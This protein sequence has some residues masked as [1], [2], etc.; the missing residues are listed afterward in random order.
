MGSATVP[1]A[2]LYSMVDKSEEQEFAISPPKGHEGEAAG[3]LTIR[4]RPPTLGDTEDYKAAKWRIRKP[5]EEPPSSQNAPVDMSGMF[6]IDDKILLIEIL[7]GRDLIVA[8]KTG[9]SDPYVK[10]DMGKE[11]LHKTA[12]IKKTLNPV[13]TEED[14][15]SYVLDCTAMDLF[16]K[17]GLVFK[18]KDW[19]RGIGGNDEMGSVKIPAETLYN[20]GPEPR[21]YPI[22]PPPGK[23]DAAG[24][25][26]LSC[27]QIS[28][29]QRDERKKGGFLKR[30]RGV[31]GMYYRRT[32][33]IRHIDHKRVANYKT[34][35]ASILSRNKI[36]WRGEYH[37][38]LPSPPV[39]GPSI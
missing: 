31:P 12:V 8:D 4:C 23:S 11:Q 15:N 1:A 19:D 10:I 7:S 33:R 39:H 9:T 29:A 38:V 5:K 32:L 36:S 22:D 34:L 13:F 17:G 20:F 2:T 24:F 25:L 28:A 37:V 35:F 21:E 30:L 3:F 26:T 16:S 18:I 14:K 27:V 6:D